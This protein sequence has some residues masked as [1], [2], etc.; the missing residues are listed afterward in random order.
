MDE[1]DLI[2][3][4]LSVCARLIAWQA[5]GGPAETNALKSIALLMQIQHNQFDEYGRTGV[6]GSKFKLKELDDAEALAPETRQ[7]QRLFAKIR[8][9]MTPTPAID[10]E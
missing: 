10:K 9:L 8:E 4:E 7:T 6:I 5:M 1:I 3:Q 2:N